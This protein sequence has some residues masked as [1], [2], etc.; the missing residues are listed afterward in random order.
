MSGVGGDIWADLPEYKSPSS[1]GA[2]GHGD[3][4]A[5]VPEYSPE[6]AKAAK[7]E[8]AK[9]SEDSLAKKV[10]RLPGYGLATALTGGAPP[11]QPGMDSFWPVR[12]AKTLY[13]GLHSAATAP[14]DVLE[15]RLDPMS[16]EGIKRANEFAGFTT[17]MAP[18]ARAGELAVAGASPRPPAPTSPMIDAAQAS[19]EAGQGLPRGKISPNLLVRGATDLLEKAPFIGTPIKKGVAETVGKTGEKIGSMAEDLAGGQLPIDRAEVG[20]ALRPSIE[21]TIES[22]KTRINDA[23]D[24][25][26]GVTDTTKPASFSHT[27]NT[28][29]A[30]RGERK[31]AGKEPDRG[32]EDIARLIKE[33]TAD[34]NGLQRARNDVGHDI[35]WGKPNPG[36]NAGDLKRVYGAMSQDMKA[37]VEK[38]AHPGVPRDL[39]GAALDLAHETT[40]GIVGENARLTKLNRI[41]SDEGLIGRVVKAAQGGNAKLVQQLRAQLPKQDFDAAVGGLLK[42]MGHDAENNVFSFDKFAKEWGK[43]SPTAKQA[44]F[45][46]AAHRQRL[47][48]FANMSKLV[49]AGD[50]PIGGAGGAVAGGALAEGGIKL[51]KMLIA[52]PKALV[53]ALAGLA[54]GRILARALAQPATAATVE[55]WT[56]SLHAAHRSPSAATKSTLTI[57]TRN[58]MNTLEGVPGF[59]KEEFLQ[60]LQSPEQNSAGNK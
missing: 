17:P 25:L 6:T 7:D 10:E 57:A 2:E 33:P 28:L 47:D 3:I 54:G 15:G 19:I 8:H 58:L 22:N 20:A 32:L 26:R 21:G 41:E 55:R 43:I 36:Y 4:W 18:G 34:F 5:D 24:A 23:Y 44:M 12:L 56:R 11:A 38:N 50:L 29:D 39:P 60:R 52:A 37:T 31:R 51:A 48:A 1:A 42:E 27:T 40:K 53:G 45:P 9:A 49:K 16:Q 30:I 35:A 59:S 13:E 14:Q 46:D